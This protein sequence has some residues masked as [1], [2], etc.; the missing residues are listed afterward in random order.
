MGEYK[1]LISIGEYMLVILLWDYPIANKRE[2]GL[3]TGKRRKTY[4]DKNAWKGPFC[5]THIPAYVNISF[6]IHI[7]Y[8]NIY[9]FL[10][11]YYDS[12]AIYN[13]I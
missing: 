7:I 1:T 4:M 6:Y 8:I 13:N 11:Y 3:G 5:I 9:I 10:Q 12:S 2:M